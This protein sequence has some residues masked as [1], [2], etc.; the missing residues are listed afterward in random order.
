MGGSA[1][2]PVGKSMKKVS[3]VS[4]RADLDGVA[5]AVLAAEFVMSRHGIPP[6]KVIFAD[7]E[8]A[9][10]AIARA[11]IDADE[12]WILDLSIREPNIAEFFKHIPRESVFYFDHHNSSVPTVEAW[13]SAASIYF[14][15]SGNYCTAD[16]LYEAAGNVAPRFAKTP[17]YDQ[18]VAA[19]H[20]RDLWVN[21]VREGA[22]LTDAIAILGAQAVYQELIEQPSSA[23]ETKFPKL[24][25]E[26]VIIA[27][28]Q[29]EAAMA[30]AN[31]TKMSIPVKPGC[32]LVYA[33]TT[34]YQSEVGHMILQQYPGSYAIMF[35]LSNLTGSIRCDKD[36]AAANGIGANNIASLFAGGGGH[37]YAA[38]FPLTTDMSRVILQNGC[39][40]THNAIA[41]LFSKR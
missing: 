8:D 29:R 10:T 25:Q 27:D 14:D 7:Y 40:S 23:F 16:L 35:N 3:I 20:S 18:L 31:N 26:A 36:T 38:G 15:D 32:N 41:R 17:V 22:L 21:D 12:L 4:H 30:M 19:T 1:D 2:R 28:N 39:M 37:P 34:G 6:E 9:K 33:I 11:A 24:F 13:D 5:S